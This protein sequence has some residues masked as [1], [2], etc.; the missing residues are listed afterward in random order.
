MF[1]IPVSLVTSLS[2][3]Y[4]V[5]HNSSAMEPGDGIEILSIIKVLLNH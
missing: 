4:S 2:S 3:M 5:Y 1:N